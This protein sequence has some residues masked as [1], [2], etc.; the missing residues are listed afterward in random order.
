M[1]QGAIRSLQSGD[2][3]AA[4]AALSH[5]ETT[6]V[7]QF[8]S[9]THEYGEHRTIQLDAAVRDAQAMARQYVRQYRRGTMSFEDAKANITALADDVLTQMQGFV[10]GTSLQ[11]LHAGNPR[12]LLG[13]AGRAGTAVASVATVTSGIGKIAG[14][15]DWFGLALGTTG[16]ASGAL[17][18][19]YA[20]ASFLIVSRRVNADKR[21]RVVRVLDSAGDFASVALGGLSTAS[22]WNQGEYDLAVATATSTALLLA[23]RLNT[24]FPNATPFVKKIPTAVVMI[25]VAAFGYK[26]IIGVAPMIGGLFNWIF[27]GGSPSQSNLAPARCRVPRHLRRRA[28]HHPPHHPPH[29]PPHRRPRRARRRRNRRK[30]R[31]RASRRHR[32]RRSRTSSSPAIRCG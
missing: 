9:Q 2:P 12:S 22:Q 11:Q 8:G 23:G 15:H 7:R 18:A 24:H 13:I 27:G 1:H 3:K 28:P 19:A 10:G 32:T 21:S 16:V 30:A 31:R 6:L 20:G 14:A 25:P 5:L 4:V 17:G 29:R 26:F